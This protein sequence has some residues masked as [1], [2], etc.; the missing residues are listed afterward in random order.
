[1]ARRYTNRRLRRVLAAVFGLAG[2]VIMTLDSLEHIRRGFIGLSSIFIIVGALLS[3][4]LGLLVGFGVGRLLDRRGF[5]SSAD[6][7]TDG[8]RGV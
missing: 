5:G 1:M 4:G 2:A 3:A 8:K 6:T 7:D